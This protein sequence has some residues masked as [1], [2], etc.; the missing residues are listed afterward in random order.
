MK[1]L[2]V[3]TCVLAAC[4]NSQREPE[5]GSS[6]ADPSA[7]PAGPCGH[8]HN[9]YEHD[10]PLHDALDLGFCS[11]EADIHLTDGALLVAHDS[12]ETEPGRTL[13][14]LYLEPLREIVNTDGV[15]HAGEG[16]LLLLIDVKTVPTDTWV[17]LDAVLAEYADILT[18][19]ED[20]EFTAGAVTAVVSGNRDRVAMEAQST[21]FAAMDGRVIDLETNP[22]VDLIP[23]ISD[24]AA[25]QLQWF[26]GELT[27]EMQQ[28]LDGIVEQ[29]H[30]Q[31][32]G[33]RLWSIPDHLIGWT[34]MVEGGVDYV[35][36]D[37][38]DGFA[39]FL[40]P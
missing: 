33:L 18:V 40:A 1:R 36:T 25:G 12:D 15:A 10:R 4:S 13:Q 35:N 30:E 31:G 39:A 2:L 29:S 32:R 21:R 6:D 38:L 16:P 3:A 5:A 27:T 24:N 26:D 8:A 19:F 7:L 34:E 22:P 11:V 23:L 9:D 37:D 28:T 20:G 14:S 17:A